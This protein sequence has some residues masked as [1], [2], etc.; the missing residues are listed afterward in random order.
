MNAPTLPSSQSLTWV[1]AIAAPVVL[2]IVAAIAASSSAGATW[3][4]L[5]ASAAALTAVY[6]DGRWQ[7]LPNW[8]TYT[9]AV[10]G[11]GLNALA[12]VAG[13][14][15]SWIGGVGLGGSL[16]GLLVLF[17]AMLV[18]FTLS[19]GGAGDV[20]FAAAVGALLGLNAGATALIYAFIIAGVWVLGVA[21]IKLGPIALFKLAVRPIVRL[22]FRG[23]IPLWLAPADSQHEE[24]ALKAPVALGPFFAAGMLLVMYFG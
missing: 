9:T 16:A 14:T 17:V 6:V 15:T 12:D 10:W 7:R 3:I 5:V 4:G 21:L 2:G 18:M 8:L 13:P 19:G 23:W 24:L 22:A 1:A 20:K 11:L